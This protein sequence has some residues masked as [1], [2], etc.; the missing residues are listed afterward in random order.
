MLNK[1]NLTLLAVV[2]GGIILRLLGI[3]YGLPHLYHFDEQ[4]E[5]YTSFYAASH[6]LKPDNFIRPMLYPTLLTII[7]LPYFLVGLILKW[8]SN[9]FEFFL[10]YIKDPSAI[11]LIGRLVNTLISI[12]TVVQIFVIG[13][14]LYS[15]KIGLI[16][17][18]FLAST[19]LHVQES[20]FMKEDTL[21]GLLSLNLF[22]FCFL[23]YR[24]KRVK[25]YIF[26]GLVFGLLASLKYN[27]F[28]FIPMIVLSFLAS[29]F[30]KITLFIIIFIIV[31]LII[32][33]YFVINPNNAFGGI[34]SQ[35]SIVA[36][37]WV[38]SE[39][40]PIWLYQLTYYFRYGLG[41]PILLLSCFGVI[42]LILRGT[43]KDRLLISTPLSFMLTLA[44][45]GGTNFSRYDV[46][47]LPQVVLI[48][49]IFLDKFIQKL[50][51]NKPNIALLILIFLMIIPSL[52]RIIKFDYYLSSPDT[53]TI[54]KVWIESNIPKETA[55]V[56]EGAV[57][58]E[59]PS[60]Y[61]PPIYLD[62]ESI[63]SL[64]KEVNQK[65][66]EGTYLKALLESRKGKIGYHLKGT[67]T[68][69]SDLNLETLQY[70][71]LKDVQEYVNYNYCYLVHNNWSKGDKTSSF[72]D[73]F[74]D[75]LDKNYTIIKE[76]YPNPVLPEDIVWRV[77]F[78][79]LDTINPINNSVISGPIIQIYKLKG[80]N[81]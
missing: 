30:Q 6:L 73:Q 39:N 3:H 32:N 62:I 75:S 72:S 67:L 79:I 47:I 41:E 44:L 81:C 65:G 29:K 7:Y 70:H 64:L 36:L 33:P 61:G 77:N 42:Y 60:I 2:L 52:L 28:I 1:V 16:A 56:N 18:F 15:V 49:A 46:M 59:N 57:R 10:A 22:Y 66:L 23:I 80:H 76:F 45:F 71:K 25:Y 68:L 31:F 21:I 27:F 19:F 20:H 14:K 13:K 54:A 78:P 35:R 9:G 63:D 55:I 8:W 51:L 37:Q 48:A 12:L 24:R 40:Q 38:S 5:I 11:L 26:A 4:S 50:K 53:R 43:K 58:S 69:D 17:T 34:L 74:K